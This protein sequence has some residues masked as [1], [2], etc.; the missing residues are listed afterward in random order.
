MS[1]LEDARQGSRAKHLSATRDV[2]FDYGLGISRP[3][4]HR[5]ATPDFWRFARSFW[6]AGLRPGEIVHNTFSY[7]LTPAG[8]MM[9]SAARAINEMGSSVFNGAFSTALGMLVR[10]L[11]LS[12]R[13]L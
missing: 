3:K 6:A 10:E 9:E 1:N 4:K 2:T 13:A 7:H 5:T 11:H 8:K 12:L